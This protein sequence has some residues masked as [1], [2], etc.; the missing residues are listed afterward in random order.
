ME[1]L[2]EHGAA[3]WGG[4]AIGRSHNIGLIPQAIGSMSRRFVQSVE[5]LFPKPVLLRSPFGF[6]GGVGWPLDLQSNN[7]MHVLN[8]KCSRSRVDQKFRVASLIERNSLARNEMYCASFGFRTAVLIILIVSL[9]CYLEGEG[10]H[11]STVLAA[12]PVYLTEQLQKVPVVLTLH[13]S[14]MSDSSVKFK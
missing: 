5:E 13:Y 1:T 6:L 9:N 11:T 10:C 3:G 14:H 12:M 8:I 4:R 2:A 7:F